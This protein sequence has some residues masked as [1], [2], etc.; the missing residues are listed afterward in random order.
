[1]KDLCKITCTDVH[2]A[3]LEFRNKTGLLPEIPLFCFK[4]SNM[5]EFRNII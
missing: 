4:P 5:H 3:N 2:R 1:V